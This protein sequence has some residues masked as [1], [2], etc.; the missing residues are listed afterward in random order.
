[1]TNDDAERAALIAGL[2]VGDRVLIDASRWNEGGGYWAIVIRI[3]SLHVVVC[4]LGGNLEAKYN[5]R[6]GHQVNVPT[7]WR[8][9]I[10]AP[11]FIPVFERAQRIRGVQANLNEAIANLREGKMGV[12]EDRLRHALA[13]VEELAKET[14]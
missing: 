12:A 5:K 1:M 8:A 4:P 6:T 11:S 3:T 14:P 10:A 9:R 13:A 2:K 7:Y